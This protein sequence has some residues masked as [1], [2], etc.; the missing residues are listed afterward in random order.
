VTQWGLS[1]HKKKKWSIFREFIE[2]P[3]DGPM[4]GPKHVG[5]FLKKF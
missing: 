3:E 1:P 2:L 4:D 5:V